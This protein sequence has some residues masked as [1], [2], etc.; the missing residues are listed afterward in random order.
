MPALEKP[1]LKDRLHES[2]SIHAGPFGG[3]NVTIEDIKAVRDKFVSC[4][5]A[6]VLVQKGAGLFYSGGLWLQMQRR[7]KIAS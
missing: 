3:K 6:F 1:Q 5:R 4:A 2:D 7:P